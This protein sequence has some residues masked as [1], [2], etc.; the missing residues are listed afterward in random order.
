[1][2]TSIPS[3]LHPG[4]QP[5]EFDQKACPRGRLC[6]CKLSRKPDLIGAGKLEKFKIAYTVSIKS[7]YACRV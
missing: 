2:S 5:W 7:M 3:I 1:M 6:P 4:G